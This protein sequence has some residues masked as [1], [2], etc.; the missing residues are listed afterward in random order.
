[1]ETQALLADIRERLVRIEERA[2]ARDQR[3]D[4]VETMV[5]ALDRFRWWILGG[6]GVAG[7]VGGAVAQHVEHL[8]R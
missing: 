5:A 3:L 8:V 6:L 7:G 1:M 2:A 4:R